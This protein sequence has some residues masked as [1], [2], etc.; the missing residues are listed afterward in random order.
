M[1]VD[2]ATPYFLDCDFPLSLESTRGWVRYDDVLKKV[3]GN[4]T[5]MCLLYNTREEKRSLHAPDSCLADGT[6]EPLFTVRTICVRLRFDIPDPTPL[7]RPMYFHRKPD[8]NSL[9]HEYWGF[10]SDH[11]DPLTTPSPEVQELR[12]KYEMHI[13]TTMQGDSW[14]ARAAASVDEK[15]SRLPGAFVA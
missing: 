9:P 10:I 12:F 3:E 7:P 13:Q 6:S 5:N 1:R 4:Q 11:E 14:N 15:I 2:A 8:P